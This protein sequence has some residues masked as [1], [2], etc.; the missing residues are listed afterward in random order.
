MGTASQTVRD[1]ED[2]Q[3]FQKMLNEVKKSKILSATKK[4]VCN[5]RSRGPLK[6]SL[7]MILILPTS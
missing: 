7:G 3:A 1:P 2:Q 6:T 5:K 4:R